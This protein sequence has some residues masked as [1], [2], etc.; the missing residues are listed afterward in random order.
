MTTTIAAV[1]PAEGLAVEAARL[2][3]DSGYRERR[4]GLFARFPGEGEARPSS[5]AAGPVQTEKLRDGGD[6]MWRLA[7]R[8]ALWASGAVFAVSL[9]VA[10][11][12]L[13]SLSSRVFLVSTVWKIGAVVGGFVG[14]FM[15]YERGVS[16]ELAHFYLENMRLGR[17]IVAARVGSSAAECQHARGLLLESGAIDVRD[18]EG[19]LEA[20]SARRHRRPSLLPRLGRARRVRGA[21]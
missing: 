1:F 16:A 2:L 11:V 18:I 19:T 13:E 12:W 14:F 10:V 4:L 8:G 3:R 5:D 20:V 21:A 17:V 6:L 9:V 7:L 15:A